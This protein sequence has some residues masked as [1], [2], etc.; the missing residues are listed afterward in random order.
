[1]LELDGAPALGPGPV[2]ARGERGERWLREVRARLE[3]LRAEEPEVP[4]AE[5]LRRHAHELYR[6]LALG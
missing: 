3:A 1:V 5:F 2:V 6:P 4:W